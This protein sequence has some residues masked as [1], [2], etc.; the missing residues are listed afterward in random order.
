M[1]ARWLQQRR[2]AVRVQSS[3]PN[4]QSYAVESGGAPGAAPRLEAWQVMT[5]DTPD[6]RAARGR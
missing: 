5:S 1:R 4:A 6:R 2:D 3:T